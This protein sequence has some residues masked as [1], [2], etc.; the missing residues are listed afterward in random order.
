RTNNA[1][2]GDYFDTIDQIRIDYTGSGFTDTGVGKVTC[3]KIPATTGVQW[4]RSNSSAANTITCSK[5][6]S[7]EVLGKGSSTNILVERW[8]ASPRAG[9]LRFRIIVNGTNAN[10][11]YTTANQSSP[12][13]VVN[14]TINI[15]AT[16]MT[17][18]NV[19]VNRT[20]VTVIRYAFTTV[21]EQFNVSVIKVT[22]GGTAAAGDIDG[23]RLIND[24]DADNV[25]DSGDSPV[26]N[27]SALTSARQYEFTGINFIVNQ[28]QTLLLVANISGAATAGRTV[29]FNINGT[30]DV[31]SLG[32]SSGANVTEVN[33]TTLQSAQATIHGRLQ[34]TG[35]DLA[36]ATKAVNTANLA[37]AYFE[38]NA[39]GE[40][41]NITAFNV[42]R[43]GSAEDAD[44]LLVRLF[45]DTN[46]NAVFD[47]G[48]DTQ[49]GAALNA[50]SSGM[51][52]FTG[53]QFNVT[54]TAN[55]AHRII[56]VAN[57]SSATAAR[58]FSFGLN[59]TGD[60]SVVGAT[61]NE[62]LSIGSGNISFASAQSGTTTIHG[63]L[64]VVGKAL[65]ANSTAINS[66]GFAVLLLNFTA[67][68]EQINVTQINLTRTGTAADVPG[69]IFNVTLVNDTD[70]S[71][72]FNEGD[73]AIVGATAV[74]TTT[75]GAY[76][77][78]AI[79]FNVTT[80]GRSVIVV[81]NTNEST[82]TGGATFNLSINSTG[83]VWAFT[84]SSNVNLSGSSNITLTT[85]NGNLTR[86][87]GTLAFAGSDLT[88]AT[89]ND[90]QL[91]VPILNLTLT[92]AGEQMNLTQ[93]NVSLNNTNNDD[94]SA[95]KL[96]NDTDRSGSINAGDYLI[97]TA[98]KTGSL[99]VFGTGTSQLLNVTASADKR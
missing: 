37:M 52:K 50:S 14:G 8:G 18:V 82:T 11:T 75:A 90:G 63:T 79:S 23:V 84:A 72:T 30:G 95:I 86:I 6:G 42:T 65:G 97:A 98:T 87:F 5:G 43:S 39:T 73:L 12:N 1:T 99:A 17:P 13:V 47:A 31:N 24:T 21:G 26:F 2:D 45:N 69:D 10:G 25:L 20:N 35:Y 66:T 51:Y 58:T 19:A 62:N 32:G 34:V 27:A 40:G 94:V 38:L 46:N 92:A 64:T 88:P 56:V 7:A 77:F 4:D 29:I 60:I 22:L 15:T 59:N 85:T 49:L 41:M 61:T 36:P 9:T 33:G 74:N 53:F 76:L 83:S 16:S 55:S 67:A 3:P 80:A 89:V 68:G 71:G 54:T 81:I 48:T 96:W 93:L 70:S 57:I 78:R 91:N 44:V 28:N